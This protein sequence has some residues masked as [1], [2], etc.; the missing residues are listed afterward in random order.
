[1]KQSNAKIVKWSDGNLSLHLGNEI[2]DVHKFVMHGD[3]NHLFIRQGNVL[4]GQAVF[5]TKLAFRP[6]SIDSMTHRKMTMSLVDHGS[7]TKKVKIITEINK[8]P[9]YNR[10]EM[11][12]KEEEK[13][14]AAARRRNQQ[15]RMREKANQKGLSA[16]YLEDRYSDDDDNGISLSAIKNK[17]KNRN[18]SRTSIYS[19]SD[20]SDRERRLNKAK[21]L[22]DDDDD[23]E[24][25]SAEEII[26]DDD[27]EEDL[28]AKKSS[29]AKKKK[30]V[31]DDED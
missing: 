1:M 2:F 31:S 20:E 21:E 25:D 15:R 27:D 29:K 17:F 19:S 30:V 6:H 11:L 7:R 13:L 28:D 23:E 3:H 5:R 18:D 24:M 10:M 16:N 4:Q 14:K 22:N 9:E 26:D 8:N 12:K